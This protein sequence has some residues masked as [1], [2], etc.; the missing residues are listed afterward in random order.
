MKKFEIPVL[1]RNVSENLIG[2]GV[3]AKVSFWLDTPAI[4][5]I[6]AFFIAMPSCLQMKFRLSIKEHNVSITDDNG[7]KVPFLNEKTIIDL[8]IV[9]GQLQFDAHNPDGTYIAGA[10]DK[11][12]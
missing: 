4:Q 8:D 5:N 11:D 7:N 9:R 12:I 6:K 2:E 3:G 1:D 10:L